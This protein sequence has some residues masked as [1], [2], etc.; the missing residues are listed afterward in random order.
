MKKHRKKLDRATKEP[1]QVV[2]ADLL[3]PGKGNGSR[4]EAVPVIMDVYSR[5]VMVHMLMDQSSEAVNN[6]LKEYVL[7]AECQAGRMIKRVITYTVKQVLTDKGGEFVNEA[8]EA[9]YNS[10]GIEH[11]QVGP[12]SS[13]LNLRKRTHQSLVEMTKA[14]MEHFGLSRSLWPEA[15]RNA[16]LN[17]SSHLKSKAEVSTETAQVIVSRLSSSSPDLDVRPGS[18]DVVASDPRRSEQA[19]KAYVA[20]EV[21]RWEQ[22]RSERVYPP[23]VEYVWSET[24]QTLLPWLSAMLEVSKFLDDRTTLNDPVQSW[25]TELNLSRRDLALARDLTAVQVP[26]ELCTAR[27]C[28]AILQTLLMEAGFQFDNLIPE[29]FR[30]AASRVMVNSVRESVRNMLRL[31]AV[32]QIEWRQLVVGAKFKIVPSLDVQ[33]ISERPPI[34]EYHAEDTKGAILMT[35]HEF[36]LLGRNYVLCL[37]MTGLRPVRSSEGSSTG[38]PNS[39]RRQYHPPRE[40]LLTSLPSVLTSSSSSRMKSI[41][42]ARTSS[43]QDADTLPSQIGTTDGSSLVGTTSGS[44]ASRNG[45]SG[46]SSAALG[47]SAASHMHYAG[48]GPMVMSA[49]ASGSVVGG[50]EMG[51][52]VTQET[53]PERR[54]KR[55]PRST[56]TTSRWRELTVNTLHNVHETLA[57]LESKTSTDKLDEQEAESKRKLDEAERRIHE[58]E[59]RAQEASAQA[60]VAQEVPVQSSARREVRSTH[61]LR[62][63]IDPWFIALQPRHT[64]DEIISRIKVHDQTAFHAIEV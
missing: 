50:G 51:F 11:I 55:R 10:R 26:V 12:K 38:E 45:S 42:N 54:Q 16:D 35:D 14:M 6:Y 15:M 19:A 64:K 36:D 28:V 3:V 41:Q 9:W 27:E 61:G 33:E 53:I 46:S 31:L 47:Y 7:W 20:R 2:Y 1:N 21:S 44:Y 25:I 59:R 39:K 30:T 57:R 56:K 40:D 58:A 8:M 23:S 5:F 52:Y 49:Q 4:F 29:W 60:T 13:Q 18:H 32:E 43:S 24:I 63:P 62:P 17:V 34:L 22:V 37:R 48:Y